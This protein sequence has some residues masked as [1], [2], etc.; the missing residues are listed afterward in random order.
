VWDAFLLL[1]KNFPVVY[2]LCRSKSL[3]SLLV[4]SLLAKLLQLQC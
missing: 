1:E 3:Q 4:H 2:Y